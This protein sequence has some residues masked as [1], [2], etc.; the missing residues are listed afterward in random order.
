MSASAE[1]KRL[2]RR[3]RRNCHY[4]G[5]SLTL[6]LGRKNTLT[7]DHVIP[8]SRGG[9]IYNGNTVSSCIQ[10]NQSKG[11]VAPQWFEE[12][13]SKMREIDT[14]SKLEPTP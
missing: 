4:C 2:W 1:R 9:A 14:Q 7:V 11:D 10:C 8:K 12:Y 13:L 6:A 3:K 5:I